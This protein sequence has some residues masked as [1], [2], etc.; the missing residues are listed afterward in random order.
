MAR[1][2]RSIRSLRAIHKETPASKNDNA[3]PDAGSNFELN[4]P[5]RSGRE[6]RAQAHFAGACNLWQKKHRQ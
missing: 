3:F 1:R 2:E 5:M 4:V 6:A